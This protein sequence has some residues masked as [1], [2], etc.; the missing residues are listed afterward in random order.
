MPSED[1]VGRVADAYWAMMEQADEIESDVCVNFNEDAVPT[2][3]GEEWLL[4]FA[5]DA[6][7][8]PPADESQFVSDWLQRVGG[9]VDA[10]CPNRTSAEPAASSAVE[11]SGSTG[12][13]ADILPITT[14]LKTEAGWSYEI[15]V[16]QLPEVVMTSDISDSPPGKSNLRLNV[17]GAADGTISS[18]DTGR[19]APLVGVTGVAYTGSVEWENDQ[20]EVFGP[21]V[22]DVQQVPPFCKPAATSAPVYPETPTYD[23]K[24]CNRLGS[25][26]QP[27]VGRVFATR[28]SLE[29][30]YEG[31]EDVVEEAI[32]KFG[33]P[34]YD[35]ISMSVVQFRPLGSA[36]DV[37]LAVGCIRIDTKTGKATARAQQG[38]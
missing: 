3:E 28:P 15:T 12:W 32:A 2:P 9:Y 20:F 8:T 16:T 36:W 7:V 6:G 19:D 31:S 22:D 18:L 13:F 14:E 21:W 30:P 26:V 34:D 5:R 27:G 25:F 17:M 1:V 24:A 29:R 23:M 35:E 38:C 10:R 37:A 11:A 4:D 33:K